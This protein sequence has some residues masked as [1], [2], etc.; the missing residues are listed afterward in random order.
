MNRVR[1]RVFPPIIVHRVR[2]CTYVH[3]RTSETSKWKPKTD[4]HPTPEL[5][6]DEFLGQ[7]FT[8]S[9]LGRSDGAGKAAYDSLLL[10][11]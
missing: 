1:L 3:R 4:S 10:Q 6:N 11:L 7:W 8:I 2:M 9:D 5:A